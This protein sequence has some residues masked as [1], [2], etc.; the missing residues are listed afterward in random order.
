MTT[1]E[2]IRQ[3]IE[4]RKQTPIFEIFMVEN[5]DKELVYKNGKHSGLPD[6]GCTDTAG[7]F[8]DLND[9]V[10]I[11]ENNIGDLRETVYDAAF[12]LC[13]FPG[14]YQSVT[15][16]FRMYFVWDGERFVQTEEPKIFKHIAL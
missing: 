12:I 7:F 9:A 5:K 11:A 13:R 15:E 16:E 4:K 2:E 6:M 1:I 14:L 8:L 10:R 3:N